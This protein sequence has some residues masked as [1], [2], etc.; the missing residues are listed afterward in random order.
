MKKLDSLISSS[1]LVDDLKYQDTSEIGNKKQKNLKEQDLNKQFKKAIKQISVSRLPENLIIHLKRFIRNPIN[2]EI[3]H[4][5]N[6]LITFELDELNLEQFFPDLGHCALY[7]LYA[8]CNHY[9]SVNN[10]HYTSICRNEQKNCWVLYD[11]KQWRT[12]SAEEVV[13]KNAYLLFY[14]KKQN[15]RF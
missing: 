3:Y 5:F 7:E 4:K 13:T 15:T 6:E 9:G 10:G 12:I 14:R 1:N 8:V 2:H 11:D